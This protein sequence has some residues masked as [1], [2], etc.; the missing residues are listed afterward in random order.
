MRIHSVEAINLQ[1]G[2]VQY[3]GFSRGKS[4]E[5]VLTQ[6]NGGVNRYLQFCFSEETSCDKD[7]VV[8]F[9]VGDDVY[10]VKRYHADDGTIKLTL[11]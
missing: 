11:K 8:T 6:R 4:T 1:T 2:E 5:K 9:S 3:F 10:S 7:V